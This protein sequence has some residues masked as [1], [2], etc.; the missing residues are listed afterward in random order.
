[1]NRLYFASLVAVALMAFPGKNLLSAANGVL[2]WDVG[3]L[4]E[5][6]YD[7]E[8]ADLSARYIAQAD[9]CLAL[10]P[11]TVTDKKSSFSEDKHY[12][13]TM[14]PYWWPEERNGKTVYVNRDGQVN[15]QSL[16]MDKA[17]IAQLGD[18][19]KLLAIAFFLTEDRQYFDAY[20]EQMDVWFINPETYM[21]P[22]F[23]YAQVVPG[24]NGNRGRSVG[25]L[26]GHG[27]NDVLESYRLVNSVK[28]IGPRR[29][30]MFTSWFRE[31]GDWMASSEQG[32]QQSKA[33]NNLGVSYDVTLLN[34]SLFV[35]DE[36]RAERL[37]REFSERR[38]FKQIE[39]DGRMPGELARTKAFSYSVYCLDFFVDFYLMADS[40]GFDLYHKDKARFNSA[41]AYLLQFVDNHEAF[42][43][44]QIIGWRDSTKSLMTQIGRLKRINPEI[45]EEL[46]AGASVEKREDLGKND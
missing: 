7:P 27:F 32:K 42:P 40:A 15:P 33:D 45:E 18:R 26:E 39:E 38:T 5:I 31:L 14:A 46:Q 29:K 41:Y 24:Q 19:M 35:G 4:N 12:Y 30:R 10:P 16:D 28:S 13:C 9:S 23:L 1:M 21:Y 17:K 6:K 43:Y 2:I 25:I 20:R 11:L 36:T 34:I 37:L 22:D 8:K 3:E 44:N